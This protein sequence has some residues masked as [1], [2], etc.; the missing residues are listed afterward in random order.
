M[1]PWILAAGQYGQAVVWRPLCIDPVH[2]GIS[3]IW[4]SPC[5]WFWGRRSHSVEPRWNH[6]RPPCSPWWRGQ[7]E[8]CLLTSSSRPLLRVPWRQSERSWSPKSEEP[9]RGVRR[10]C[11]GRD[12]C[13]GTEWDGFRSG[14][15][16]WLWSSPGA[17]A[18]RWKS[19]QDSA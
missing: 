1:F 19:V 12:Q 18:S 6:C 2:R 4:G 10:S 5:F 14:S 3:W 16:W 11:R 17:G 15:G 9:C 13:F 7:H 8:R